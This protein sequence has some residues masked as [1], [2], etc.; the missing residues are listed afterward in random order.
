[1]AFLPPNSQSSNMAFLPPNSQSSNMAFLPPNSQP[2]KICANIDYFDR[3]NSSS[4]QGRD[5]GRSTPNRYPP[6]LE[7]RDLPEKSCRGQN[8]APDCNTP[9][10]MLTDEILALGVENQANLEASGGSAS[11]ARSSFPQG[12]GPLSPSAIFGPEDSD[13]VVPHFYPRV[14]ARANDLMGSMSSDDVIPY[15][16][17]VEVDSLPGG[18]DN[19]HR[20]PWFSCVEE[21]DDHGPLVEEVEDAEGD[22]T[23]RVLLAIENK[24]I[25]DCFDDSSVRCEDDV[26]D[27]LRAP[28]DVTHVDYSTSTRDG[29]MKSSCLSMTNLSLLCSIVPFSNPVEDFLFD[30]DLSNNKSVQTLKR[31]EIKDQIVKSKTVGTST[32]VVRKKVQ[33]VQTA[34]PK[35]RGIGVNTVSVKLKSTSVMTD[36][37]PTMIPRRLRSIG[38]GTIGPR[39]REKG[40]NTGRKGRWDIEDV[41]KKTKST[42]TEHNSTNSNIKFNVKSFDK[43][44]QPIVKIGHSIGTQVQELVK[45]RSPPQKP[46]PHKV[47]VKG[48]SLPNSKRK[49]KRRSR[50]L[51]K[52]ALEATP[53]TDVNF[54][55]MHSKK[56]RRRTNT[57]Q[58]S[59]IMQSTLK[60]ETVRSSVV[61]NVS[62]AQNGTLVMDGQAPRYPVRQCRPKQEIPS[63]PTIKREPRLSRFNTDTIPTLFK[64]IHPHHTKMFRIQIERSST[65]YTANFFE[66]A[67]SFS[68]P[69]SGAAIDLDKFK[70]MTW[71]LENLDPVP[72]NMWHERKRIHGKCSLCTQIIDHKSEHH[73]WCSSGC[74]RPYHTRCVKD[75]VEFAM[76]SMLSESNLT[77]QRF[78][79][80]LLMHKVCQDQMN[81]QKR[82]SNYVNEHLPD[83]I[84]RCP[85]CFRARDPDYAGIPGFSVPVDR[86]AW[87]V[88]TPGEDLKPCYIIA[89]MAMT[90]GDINEELH[91][92]RF[93]AISHI[94]P[95]QSN[96]KYRG[97]YHR[98]VRES[99][100][101]DWGGLL[102]H[103]ALSDLNTVGIEKLSVKSM[104]KLKTRFDKS[105][106]NLQKLGPTVFSQVHDLKKAV[107]LQPMT[108]YLKIL[109][110]SIHVTRDPKS[111]PVACACSES[112]TQGIELLT[113]L[114]TSEAF[115]RWDEQ[116]SV[117]GHI[118]R[119][120][121]WVWPV[122]PTSQVFELYHWEEFVAYLT[123]EWRKVQKTIGI[124]SRPAT[125]L[126]AV[127]DAVAVLTPDSNE[128]TPATLAVY[129]R[130]TSVQTE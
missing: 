43:G 15:D 112:L 8:Q 31:F 28:S 49:K 115:P 67:V 39:T 27:L 5:D 95:Q 105:T 20:R 81:P 30:V 85:V 99:D 13:P 2:S 4:C 78:E 75:S 87:L 90:H 63:I 94:D 86:F 34:G 54:P 57:G 44:S 102:R 12:A 104:K 97:F 65:R 110:S 16:D 130:M 108:D 96:T 47:S 69:F 118:E 35:E 55:P 45:L 53:L 48:S 93:Y 128:N 127:E 1:M 61:P 40:S 11:S 124:D 77:I 82:R 80:A 101:V 62:D 64:Q 33:S 19:P 46:I 121:F 51:E 25:D 41:G 129:Q 3:R 9:S 83:N 73:V 100:V 107:P 6:K 60:T 22:G 79:T 71:N 70:F 84:H 14:K 59:T 109:H 125:P 122:F 23:G 116:S 120:D 10:L 74:G 29:H 103:E 113:N 76:A 24:P 7:S 38:L 72:P 68:Q 36:P 123:D 119:K 88:G 26:M 18:C 114:L 92:D 89:K 98:V 56:R 17:E 111:C 32:E 50:S 58:S 66:H 117:S 126:P 52:R 42:I 21:D 106:S 37:E 91:L